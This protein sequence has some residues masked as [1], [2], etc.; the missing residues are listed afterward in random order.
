M[1]NV[2]ISQL[3]SANLLSQTDILPSVSGSTT[4]QI[5]VK[6]LATSIL[7][8]YTGSTRMSGSLGITGSVNFSYIIAGNSINT[9]TYS[10]T[11]GQISATGSLLGTASLAT[12]SSYA[13][14]ASYVE[15]SVASKL[16]LFFNY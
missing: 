9:F 13:V 5:A 6:D 11:T 4:T 12:S 14:T 10:P 7:Q 3:P 2:K 8:Q 16:Y 1:A 15:P